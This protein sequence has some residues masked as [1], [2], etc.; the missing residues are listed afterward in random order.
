MRNSLRSV[1]CILQVTALLLWI[2][3]AESLAG[4]PQGRLEGLVLDVAGRPASGHRVHLIDEQGRALGHSE[5]SEDGIYSFKELPAGDYSLGI[6][7]P[8]GTVAPV[9]APAVRLQDRALARRDLKLVRAD[10]AA[11]DQAAEGNYGFSLWWHGLSKAGKAWTVLAIV[12]AGG[13]TYEALSDEDEG[14]RF[15]PGP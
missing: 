1:A 12:V 2:I 15:V 10:T 8:D 3:P 9:A 6:E 14:S 11:V 5:V 4:S 7:S 13:L